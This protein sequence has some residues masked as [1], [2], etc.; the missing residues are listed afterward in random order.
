MAPAETAG[1]WLAPVAVAVP[2]LAACVLQ[3]I[4]RRVPQ[5]GIDAVALAVSLAVVAVDASMLV[6]TAQ[7][8][9]VT[10]LGAWRPSHR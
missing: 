4:E 7:G 9:I 2:I 3:L 1:A 8:R 5:R 6:S 10:W